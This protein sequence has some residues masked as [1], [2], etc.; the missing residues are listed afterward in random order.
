MVDAA[1]LCQSASCCMAHIVAPSYVP[2][3]EIARP[4]G[5]RGEVRLKLYNDAS[6]MIAKGRKVTLLPPENGRSKKTAPDI[7]TIES[8]RATSGALLVQL[9]GL[10]IPD[11][12]CGFGNAGSGICRLPHTVGFPADT[13]NATA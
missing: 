8:V 7:R 11:A 12:G 1:Q 10:Q 5:V 13:V 6:T 4:H 2:I 3:A 9:A